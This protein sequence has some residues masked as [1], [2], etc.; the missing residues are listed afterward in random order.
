MSSVFCLKDIWY[1][2]DICAATKLRNNFLLLID[3]VFLLQ[4]CVQLSLV[5]CHLSF[6]KEGLLCE[7]GYSIQIARR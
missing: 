7:G 4:L 3:I 2:K 1:I 6:A 5:G